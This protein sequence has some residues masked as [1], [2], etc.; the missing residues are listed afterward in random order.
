M[1]NFVKL[2]FDLRQSQSDNEGA[3]EPRIKRCSLILA[4]AQDGLD[5]QEVTGD[6][7]VDAGGIQVLGKIYGK[8]VHNVN[9]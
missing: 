9:N 5:K 3:D 7:D 6:D 1:I 8:P 2:N 4:E